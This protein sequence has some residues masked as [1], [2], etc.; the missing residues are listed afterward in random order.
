MEADTI[1]TATAGRVC[2]DAGAYVSW[3]LFFERAANVPSIGGRKHDC[4]NATTDDHA[5][6]SGAVIGW[7]F[8]T[9]GI[10]ERSIHSETI[11]ETMERT[12]SSLAN[13]KDKS[14]LQRMTQKLEDERDALT[15]YIKTSEAEVA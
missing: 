7:E 14:L 6:Y 5:F 13:T 1:K 3:D 15:C 10:A 2:C 4:A 9:C 12:Q 8:R 11:W